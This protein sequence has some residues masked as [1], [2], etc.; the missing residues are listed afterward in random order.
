[1]PT[2]RRRTIRSTKGRI[3]RE[4][5]EAF[6]AGDFMALHRALD[7]PPWHPSPLPESVEPLGVDPDNPPPENSGR[8]WDDCW[9]QAVALQRELEAAAGNF[10]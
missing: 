1:M 3:T 7:L 2:M 6:K 5:V 4:A 10:E 9:P 8:C